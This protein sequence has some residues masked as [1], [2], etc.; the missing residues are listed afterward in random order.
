M[1]ST[2]RFLF[3]PKANLTAIFP[4]RVTQAQVYRHVSSV[5]KRG[6]GGRSSFSGIVATVFGG[7]GFLGRYIVNRL[8]RMGS[9][10]VVPYRGDEFDYR[11]LRPMGDLGQILFVVSCTILTHTCHGD[12]H[13]EPLL[14]LHCSVQGAPCLPHCVTPALQSYNL[15]DPESVYKAVKHS[16]VVINLAGRD[17]ETRYHGTWGSRGYPYLFSGCG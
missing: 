11:H 4:H 1:A 3:G 5:A 15:R 12:Q 8:G 17:Y 6:K 13:H 7:P 10:V 2:R 16:T 14:S 9:Q